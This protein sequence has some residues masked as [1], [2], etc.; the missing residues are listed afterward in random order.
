MP[1]VGHVLR[2]WLNPTETFIYELVSRL[3]RYEPVVLARQPASLERFP[4]PHL[5]AYTESGRGRGM[6]SG[7]MSVVE[8]MAY[9]GLRLCLPHERDWYA[10]RL[11][12]A[13]LSLVHGHFGPDTRYFLPSIRAAGLPFIASFHGYDATSFPR[14]WYGLGRRYLAPVFAEAR[15]ITVVSEYMRGLLV[16][17]GCPEQ[18][19]RVHHVG[20]DLER[21][22]FA[23]RR[24]PASPQEPIV[25]VHV[26]RFVPK[27]GH[28]FLLE[29]LAVVRRLHE[30]QGILPRPLQVQ[31]IGDGPLRA[32]IER[33]SIELGLQGWVECVGYQPHPQVAER[34]RGAHVYLQPSITP[35]DGD[36][37]GIPTTLMEA[38][39]VGL[40]AIATRHA[41]IPELV[42]DGESGWLVAEHDVEGLARVLIEFCHQPQRWA[43]MG[44]AGR[45]LV[46]AEFNAA[47]QA[48]RIE[49]LYDE[50]LG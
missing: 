42:R 45:R 34:L 44:H 7:G 23:V 48:R 2:T 47:V 16:G 24:P 29:A 6:L 1:R 12:E 8:E 17:L 33:L 26:A 27:K 22:P 43:E 15:L 38:Q 46:E 32:D 28:A 9:R 10:A 18:K 14:K 35:P 37:E 4:T 30:S 20:I 25:A 36:Q 21:F 31:L 50:A 40:P 41:G 19:L 39:A 49:A 13:G 5:H 3:E 11:R